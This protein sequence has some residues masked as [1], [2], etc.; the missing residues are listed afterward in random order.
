MSV[1]LNASV[2]SK[3]SSFTIPLVLS[4]NSLL[5]LMLESDKA[6]IF[7]SSDWFWVLGSGFWVLGSRFWLVSK[8]IS[9][10]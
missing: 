10:F 3:T 7:G 1:S 5:A 4:S 6:E 8:V 2:G 9:L